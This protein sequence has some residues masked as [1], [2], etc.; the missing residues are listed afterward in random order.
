[1]AEATLSFEAVSK[2][3]A[4]RPVLREVS[5]TCP[6]GTITALLGP[7]G[8]GKTTTVSVA[9][10]LRRPDTGRVSVLGA[11]V[12]TVT[13][14]R[15]VSLVP[16]EIGFPETVSVEQCLD[17]VAAQRPDGPY[18]PTRDE[19][20]G[21]LGVSALRNRRVGGL[22]GGERRKLAVA[23]GLIGAPEVL[24]LDEATTNLDE[25]SRAATW[26][27]VSEYTAAGGTAL[28]TSHILADI[29]SHADRVVALNAG[30]V[31]IAGPLEGIR[32]SL[33]G[34]LVQVFAGAAAAATLRAQ[35]A[36][37]GLGVEAPGPLGQVVWRSAQPL[38][39]VQ[40]L[41]GLVP[42]NAELVVRPVP[43]S[44]LLDALAQRPHTG[45]VGMTE[46]QPPAPSHHSIRDGGRLR[47]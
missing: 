31:V 32:A 23:L 9:T 46:P 34:S 3:L 26:S 44:E 7:N 13:A 1:M 4:A 47:S 35:V 36:A 37:A 40:S 6:A 19:L 18:S 21:R 5:F 20:C 22:S 25:S 42:P 14:R 8:A 43:L 15:Q 38:A 12:G 2:S 11:T 30:Q 27:L 16:Q 24:I 33:G 45:S 29:E 41:T 17:F 39:L 28:V 10:G